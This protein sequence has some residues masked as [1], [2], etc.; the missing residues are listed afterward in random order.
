MRATVAMIVLAVSLAGCASPTGAPGPVSSTGNQQSK[1]QGLMDDAHRMA[2]SGKVFVLH[3]RPIKAVARGT[4]AIYVFYNNPRPFCYTYMIPGDWVSG[5]EAGSYVSEDG[6]AFV[7]VLFELSKNFEGLEGAT[8]VQRA[9]KS[10]SREYEK[11]L[12][13]RLAGIELD[14][15]E[16]ARPGTWKWQADPVTQGN[17]E[18]TAASKFIIDLNPHEAVAIITI[19][20]TPDDDGLARRIIETLKTTSN[21]ECYWPVLEPLLKS[22]T[23]GP[24]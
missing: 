14:P 21:P 11:A 7:G 9:E 1:L 4:G 10:I 5:R 8:L 6:R 20:G 13:V 22:V 12:G 16:S 24:P 19:Q 18:I 23:N 15:F 2:A 17:H 3:F